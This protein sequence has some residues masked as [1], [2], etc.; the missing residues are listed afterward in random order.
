MTTRR[1]TLTAGRTKEAL[2]AMLF[3]VPLLPLGALTRRIGCLA[4]IVRA[5]SIG[6]V[7]FDLF[8]RHTA[9]TSY[10]ELTRPARLLRQIVTACHVDSPFVLC[11]S[12]NEIVFIER[13]PD[14]IQPYILQV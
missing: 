14:A 9:T 3:A 10:E 12:Y 1:Q 13:T 11:C 7:E 4:R 6:V 5:L 8:I 2:N